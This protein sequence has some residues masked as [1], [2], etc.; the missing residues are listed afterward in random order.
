MNILFRPEVYFPKQPRKDDAQRLFGNLTA[1]LNQLDVPVHR[2]ASMLNCLWV[3]HC[4]NLFLFHLFYSFN[5]RPDEFPS[6]KFIGEHRDIALDG[7]FGFGFSGEIRAPFDVICERLNESKTPIV[8]IDIP[9]GWHVEEGDISGQGLQ[10]SLLISLTCPKM[11]AD[12][13]ERDIDDTSKPAF[14]HWLGG[15]FL[16]PYVLCM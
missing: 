12:F 14:Q 1:Q 9:S 3:L 13:F 6:S 8:S 7:I 16:A 2:E 4:G 15:R 10:A 5:H 11:N